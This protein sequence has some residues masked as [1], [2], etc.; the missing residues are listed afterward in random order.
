MYLLIYELRNYFKLKQKKFFNLR[1]I[2]N[3]NLLFLTKLQVK[4]N[5]Y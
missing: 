5:I 2:S 1:Y 4:E 3:L